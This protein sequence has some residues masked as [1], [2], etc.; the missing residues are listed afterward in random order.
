M[1]STHALEPRHAQPDA[2]SRSAS[3]LASWGE[4][5]GN[6]PWGPGGNGEVGG[7]GVWLRLLA[8]PGQA[9]PAFAEGGGCQVVFDGALYNRDELSALASGPDGRDDASLILRAYERWGE[10]LFQRLRGI[11]ALAIADRD[12]GCLLCARDPL[13]IFPLFIAQDGSTLFLSTT[14]AALTNHPR[15]SRAINRAAL[16]DHLCSRWPIPEE[17]CFT[18]VSRVLPGH[19]LRVDRHGGRRMVRYWDPAPPGAPISWIRDEEVERF[20]ELLDRAVNRCLDQGPAGIFLSGGL[21]S[22]S[23][24]ALAADNCRRRNLPTPWALSLGF[25][26]PECNEEAIQ[27]SIAASLGLPQ[28][29]LSFD[30]AIGPPGVLQANLDLSADWPMPPLGT[31][32]PAYQTLAAEGRRR[33]CRVILTGGGGDEWL[34]VGPAY[35]ADLIRSL[36][37]VRL[38]GLIAN[39]MRS[40]PP[41]R[42]RI[43]HS[44]V[45]TFGARALLRDVAFHAYRRMGPSAVRLRLRRA[46][47]RTVPSWVA[48]DPLLRRELEQRLEGY[49]EAT[50]PR[51]HPDSFYLRACRES[52]ESPLVSIEMEELFERGRRLGVRFLQPYWDADLADFLYRTPPRLLNWGGRSKGLVRPM[53][54]RR[55]PQATFERQKKVMSTNFFRAIISREGETAWQTMGGVPELA[56]LGLVDAAALGDTRAAVLRDGSTRDMYRLWSALN[57]ESWIRAH[58]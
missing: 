1:S 10:S 7:Q 32:T 6:T 49:L 56:R 15:V 30:A 3:W 16:A 35:A 40:F 36:D 52:F 46:I 43:L 27:R 38:V 55:F 23:V 14:I 42:R 57:L 5:G 4:Y 45:W 54:A 37:L 26:D 20:D 21:D 53:L 11:F 12:Q 33:G 48:P 28:E 8:A 13:G 22:V 18:A 25:P 44:L 58:N 41:P 17:T 29:L 39:Y 34:G 19:V 47:R 2:S 31:W 9:G 24:A 50:T 51:S